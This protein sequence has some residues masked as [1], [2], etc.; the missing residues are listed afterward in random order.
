MNPASPDSCPVL[1][2]TSSKPAPLTASGSRMSYKHWSKESVLTLT[3]Y[4]VKSNTRSISP[5]SGIRWRPQG[6]S[7]PC[8]C[9]ERA[10]SW[11]SR[12]WG[13]KAEKNKPPRAMTV[14]GGA[15]RDR[16]DDLLHAMQALSQLS[17]GPVI[18]D[19]QSK[20]FARCCQLFPIQAIQGV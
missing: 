7:N 8:Y 13:Q 11:A 18:G 12:R 5:Q 6:D 19:G 2:M 4:T 3:P 15:R 9:R 16:T 14:S 17:Y 1:R 10:V 20:G